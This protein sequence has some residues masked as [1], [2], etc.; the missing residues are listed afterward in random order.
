VDEVPEKSQ[1]DVFYFLERRRSRENGMMKLQE[2]HGKAIA[3]LTVKM[4]LTSKNVK[5]LLRIVKGFLSRS[6]GIRTHDLQHPMLARYQAT[7]HPGNF[8]QHNKNT[9]LLQ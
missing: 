1:Q 4:M 2:L 6:G 8:L 3:K 5:S 9:A 7:L